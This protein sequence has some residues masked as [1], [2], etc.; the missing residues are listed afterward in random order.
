MNL[1]TEYMEWKKIATLSIEYGV[2]TET[3]SNMQYGVRDIHQARRN[4]QGGH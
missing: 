2:N 1:Y 4:M 3:L